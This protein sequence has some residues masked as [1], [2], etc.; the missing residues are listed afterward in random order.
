MK[1]NVIIG[2]GDMEN[3][4]FAAR[5]AESEQKCLDMN[6]DKDTYGDVCM[7]DLYKGVRID[8]SNAVLEK[9]AEWYDYRRAQT[10]R[11][12]QREIDFTA[13]RLVRILHF[14][15]EKLTDAALRAVKHFFNTYNFESIY[16]SEN[17]MLMFRLSRLI[18]AEIYPDEFL[19]Y[20][21]GYAKDFWEEDDKFLTDYMVFRA[22]RGWAEFD[23]FGYMGEI[24][25]C[26]LTIRDCTHDKNL[27]KLCEESMNVM[28]LDIFGDS[29]DGLY[30]GAHGRIYE[31]GAL[32]YSGADV[33]GVVKYYFGNRYVDGVPPLHFQLMSDY[34]PADY[35]CEAFAAMPKTHENFESKHLHCISSTL[36]HRQVPQVPGSINKYTYVTPDFVIGA[37]NFQDKYPDDS[38]AKWYAHHEQHEW[39]LTL[40]DALDCRIFTHHPGHCGDEGHEHGRWTGDL[41]CCC[42]Q[43]F[44]HKNI[45]IATY[46]IPDKEVHLINAMVPHKYFEEIFDGNYI[47]LKRGKTYI[48]LYFSQGYRR[49]CDEKYIDFEMESVGQK[50]AVVCEAATAAEY[51]DFD[52]FIKNIKSH[53]VRFDEDKMTVDYKNLRLEPDNRYIDGTAVKFPYNTYE[54]PVV[55]EKFGTGKIYVGGREVVDFNKFAK[56]R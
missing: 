10:G 43:F 53:P 17:H 25:K 48:S 11:D 18:Y 24:Y 47:F 29:M 32:S 49:G 26:L 31:G 14:S 45:V 46:D 41:G 20:Y 30:G 4:E 3:K 42:G 51:A 16:K 34:V 54:N 40:P 1:Y 52:D 33:M 23:S 9:I 35:V 12:P 6:I 21:N 27:A 13:M 8:E 22:K 36:P 2:G 5:K 39:D 44:C 37:V 55:L 19:E 56:E 50:H 7:Y 38:D 15:A 28:F